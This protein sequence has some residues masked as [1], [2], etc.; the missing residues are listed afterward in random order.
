MLT[1]CLAEV[2]MRPT[3]Q[4]IIKP[5]KEIIELDKDAGPLCSYQGICA[6][7]LPAHR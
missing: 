4:E 6:G 3:E 7:L 5:H 1:S 2:V